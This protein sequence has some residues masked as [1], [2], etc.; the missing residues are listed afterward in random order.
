MGKKKIKSKIW[1][2]RTTLP[3]VKGLLGNIFLSRWD[4]DIKNN[5]KRR[6]ISQK[7]PLKGSS[8]RNCALNSVVSQELDL[9]LKMQLDMWNKELDKGKLKKVKEKSSSVDSN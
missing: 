2:P 1:K 3:R 9:H 8:L 4:N 7:I 6:K 5:N